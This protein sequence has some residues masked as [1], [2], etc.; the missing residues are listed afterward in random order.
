MVAPKVLNITF[1]IV[2][3]HGILPTSG[4]IDVIHL[5]AGV[6]EEIHWC[7]KDQDIVVIYVATPDGFL[8]TDVITE[9]EPDAHGKESHGGNRIGGAINPCGRAFG[10]DPLNAYDLRG[11]TPTMCAAEAE[12]NHLIT[13]EHRDALTVKSAILTRFRLPSR[14]MAYIWD[15]YGDTIGDDLYVSQRSDERDMFCETPLPE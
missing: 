9:L 8:V 5:P 11:P 13:V 6:L 1:G 7:R 15:H 12:A 10:V 3:Q 2:L 14:L 4:I